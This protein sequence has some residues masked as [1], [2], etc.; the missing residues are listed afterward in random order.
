MWQHLF[1][2]AGQ[3]CAAIQKGNGDRQQEGCL[4]KG[5]YED[6]I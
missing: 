2:M 3:R 6:R 4:G 5:T 1:C